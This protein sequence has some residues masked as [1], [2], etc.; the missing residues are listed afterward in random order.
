[1]AET[2]RIL[3]SEIR[4]AVDVI[5]AQLEDGFIDF[6]RSDKIEIGVLRSA[7]AFW[8][9]LVLIPREGRN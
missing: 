9:D 7:L 8:E 2:D 4:A 5:N 1:M 3:I 6:G